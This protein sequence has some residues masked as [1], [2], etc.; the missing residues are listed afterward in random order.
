MTRRKTPVPEGPV[1]GTIEPST[2][3]SIDAP[4]P[5]LIEETAGV[6]TDL[7]SA[8]APLID[9]PLM[10][11]PATE[12]PQIQTEPAPTV[13]RPARSLGMFGPILGGALAAVAGFG[14]SQSNVL[15]LRPPD[16]SAEMT[17]LTDQQTSLRAEVTELVDRIAAL[18][19]RP[20]PEPPDLSRLD[21]LDQRLQSVESAPPGG[22][23]DTTDLAAR[24][25]AL[26]GTV[27]T[28]P[29]ASANPAEIDEALTRLAEIDAALARLEELEAAA[30]AQSVAAAETAR[31]AEQARAL[32]GL[33]GAVAEGR[34]FEAELAAVT[35]PDLQAALTPHISG[36]TPLADLQA[37]FPD[38]ARAALQLARR[39]DGDDSWGSRLTDFLADQTG[40]RSVTPREGDDPDAILSRA[41]F[42]LGESRLSDALTELAAL[43]ADIRAPLE[44]WIAKATARLAVDTA[45][46]EAM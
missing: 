22:T 31:A 9:A 27:A 34:G 3:A 5:P 30:E 19:S 28:L 36:V 42:A 11:P 24:L 6:E 43:P 21:E 35:N 32:E 46:M 16:R 12:A 25:S 13:R 38:A 1:D 10:D 29:P 8:D 33:A 37:Q 17:A 2:T 15:G 14:L 41:E 44:E 40:A 4:T 18:E 20:L 26:E 39:A 45:L 7:P 23:A